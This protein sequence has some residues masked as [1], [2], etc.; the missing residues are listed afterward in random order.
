MKVILNVDAISA[1]LTG[2][3]T[4]ALQLARGLAARPEL[5]ALRLFSA[6]RWVDDAEQALRV[7]RHIA[8]LRRVAPFKRLALEG[9][10]AL[11]A[12]LFRHHAAALR[13]HVLHSPN[14]VLM[15]FDGPAVAT[16]HDISYL[17]YPQYHPVERVRLL[18]RHLPE[19]LQRA[20][21][22]IVDS[23]C[24]REELLS[25]FGVDERKLHTVPLGVDAAFRPR[26]EA[27]LG[28]TLT[29]LGLVPDGYLL[30]VATLEPRKNLER[31]V[32]AYAGLPA[33]TRARVPLAVVG[34]RGW[35]DG[36]L[37]SAL[38]P[39]E[40]VGQ[41]R[42]LGYI[43]AATLPLVY[44]GALGFAL[45]SLYEGFGLPVL[46]AMASGV[47]VLTSHEG[48]LAEVASDAALRVDPL[49]V[50]AI[51]HGLVRMT[52]DAQ[53]RADA[54]ARGV[55]LAAAYTWQRCVDRTL[56][57]YRAAMSA[58]QAPQGNSVPA[59][60]TAPARPIGAI[61]VNF[62]TAERTLRCV[63]SLRP[64][65]A[66]LR[67]IV[68][69]S[70]SR[71]A[72]LA[73][74]RDGLRQRWPEAELIGSPVNIGFAAGCNR[75]IARFLDDA[76]V[77]HVLLLNNDA[78][79]TPALH[80]WLRGFADGSDDADLAGGRVLKLD[81]DAVDSLGIAFYRSLLAS[82]RMDAR[83]PYFGPTGG[84]AVYARRVLE[85]LRGAD[86]AVF[87]EDFFCYAED[88]DVAARALLRGFI[89]AYRDDVLARHEGQASSGGGFNDFVLYHGIR[90]SLWMLV[91]CVPT[92]LIV[93]N[94]LWLVTMHAG[95]VVRHGLR[96]RFGV[97][98]RLYRDALRGLPRMRR[99]R[100]QICSQGRP[101]IAAF[102]ARVSPR[103]Y[104]RGYLRNALHEL[105]GGAATPPPPSTDGS[106]REDRRET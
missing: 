81:V 75:A 53:W 86:G 47:P 4:Y 34:A 88:T 21:A 69:D 25:V 68:I 14:F 23:D 41:V 9:Y 56:G 55:A 19:T 20:D 71:A 35:L 105:W 10:T 28:A 62:N 13:D 85:A 26:S 91:K 15:P 73:A 17:R 24:V 64:S 36:P 11:R 57:A 79:A 44:A 96:G 46:E 76:G 82:N 2:I 58:R 98:W 6:Y 38:E 106:E 30:V 8:T 78:L 42:R 93:R 61:L 72:D 65:Q 3:G 84:C 80:D 37:R 27:E 102:A 45:P 97:V 22:L 94:L 100:W 54:A 5:E 33:A 1:P 104:D 101:G 77:T 74:L 51:R 40:R 103:F 39:L 29:S 43:D 87:D 90:N 70:G 31:L 89:P 18:E 32:Q 67:L 48:A 59:Y 52:E 63:D 7:N 92:R 95:I 49:D 66:M 60:G 50:E 12:R 16:V 99:K 83:E